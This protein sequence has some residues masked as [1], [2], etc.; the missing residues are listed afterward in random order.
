MNQKAV[1][2][3]SGGLDST[4]LAA[5]VVKRGYDVF[6]VSFDYGQRHREKELACA[7]YQADKLGFKD[8]KVIDLTAIN[9]IFAES[10]S[11]LVTD[12]SVPEGHYGEES[13]KSTVVPNRNMIM[14]SIAA[15]YCVS[16][17]GHI[18]STGVHAGDHFIYPD[19]RPSFVM[20][21]QEAILTGNEGFIAP[22]WLLDAPFLY[23]TKN[24]IADAAFRY[25][26]DIANTWSCYNGGDIHCG[27]CG[28]CVERIEALES[29]KELHSEFVDP[30]EYEDH[31]FWKT[32]LLQRGT[33]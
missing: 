11:S 9:E 29:V 24:Q 10:G 5:D 20:Y 15:G 16:I 33:V 25:D 26:V 13:M 1:V 31:E 17:G 6:G 14:M 7:A 8:H 21:L 23:W 2:V 12:A 30:T 4:T 3:I 28:T 18:L 22:E 32:A 19:C 27:K